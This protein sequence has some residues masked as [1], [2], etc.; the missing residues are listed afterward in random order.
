M[1][2]LLI[3]F[4]ILFSAQSQQVLDEI[5]AIVG[6][7]IITKSELDQAVMQMKFQQKLTDA[8]ASARR[9][10]ILRQMVDENLFYIQSQLD[11]VEVP[12]EQLAQESDRRWKQLVNQVASYGGEGYLEQ[13]YNSKVRDIRKRQKRRL[14]RELAISQLRS[15][16]MRDIRVSRDEVYTFYEQYQDSLPVQPERVELANI[17]MRARAS[18]EK[19]QEAFEK[20]TK[21]LA[22][23]NA[24]ENFAALAKELSEGPSGPN[25]G[26]LG[27]VPKGTF[28]S[29]FEEAAYLLE[30]GQRSTAPVKTPFGY[31]LIL[32]HSKSETE[33]EASHILFMAQVSQSDLADTQ[34]KLDSIRNEI[35]LGNVTFEEAAKTYSE[36]PSTNLKGGYLGVFPLQSIPS[37]ATK[38]QLEPLTAGTLSPV[39]PIDKET[40]QL[41]KM[42]KRIPA[43]KYDI[44]RDFSAVES[45]AIKFK[46]TET[47]ADLLETLKKTIPVEIH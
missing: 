27:K 33:I 4:V 14:K 29:E 9:A 12:E 31:H 15:N 23:L 39:F 22:R 11:S 40:V 19:E 30:T 16:L 37:E 1:K 28:V 24:G 45:M 25:G 26:S 8:Q 2:R 17:V 41:V 36:D 35:V 47:F 10:Q 18:A 32:L 7:E 38:K 6:D 20:A 43:T 34:A 3:L 21:A 46:Q 44:D 42:I 5:L 13:V